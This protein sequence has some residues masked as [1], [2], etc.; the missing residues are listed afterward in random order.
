MR[1][2][3][4]FL[5]IQRRHQ[6]AL[7]SR[8]Q[9]ESPPAPALPQSAISFRRRSP[10]AL[11]RSAGS[12]STFAA[13]AT[14]R[15]SRRFP[16]LLLTAL[17]DS[18]LPS[19]RLFVGG[20]PRRRFKLCVNNHLI[21][22]SPNRSVSRFI[23]CATRVEGS[24]RLLQASGTDP[25]AWQHPASP[26]GIRDAFRVF[27]RHG[28]PRSFSISTRAFVTCWRNSSRLALQL[29][30]SGRIEAAKF[31]ELV[32]R[33]GA[34]MRVTPPAA[35]WAVRLACPTARRWFDGWTSAI[36]RRR[37]RKEEKSFHQPSKFQLC[38]THA[39]PRTLHTP[40]IPFAA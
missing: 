29:A 34:R 30:R 2:A 5:K 8:L 9:V 20:P 27:S 22:R 26:T 24:P 19:K 15:P 21:R 6:S 16:E 7:A 13:A 28:G 31:R 14:A 18:P 39:I 10:A 11:A 12:K 1:W 37:P 36:P 38:T 3:R 25:L 4:C 32:I 33:A 23:Q 17:R 40:L 35:R